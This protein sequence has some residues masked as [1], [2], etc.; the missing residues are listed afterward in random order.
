LWI[1]TESEFLV[2]FFKLGVDMSTDFAAVLLSPYQNLHPGQSYP[3]MT[4]YEYQFLAQ[5]DSWFS[6][7]AMPPSETTNILMEMRFPK[8]SCIV[9]C[10][11]PGDTLAHMVTWRRNPLFVAQLVG[12]TAQTWDAILLSAGGN[13]LIDAAGVLPKDKDGKAIPLNQRL[14]RTMTEWTNASDASKYISEPGW[15]LFKDH[16]GPQFE[17]LIKLRDS[18]SSKNKN[19]PVFVH[20]YDYPTP[21]NSPVATFPFHMG[22][23]LYPALSAFGV[24]TSDWIAVAKLLID[25]L[26]DVIE[27]LATRLPSLHVVETRDTLAPAALGSTGPSGDWL[28]EIHPTQDGYKLLAAKYSSSVLAQIT[29]PAAAV[30]KLVATGG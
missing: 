11:H 23:W 1:A 6:I 30:P 4:A 15:T 19:V 9:N 5:G 14:F 28:N 10:A 17:E 22:P 21:R 24:P 26:A 7:G 16:L 2:L 29:G 3:T 18:A 27:G 13:D 25:R 12:P 20:L 8:P